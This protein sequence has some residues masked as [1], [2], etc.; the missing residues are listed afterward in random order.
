[1]YVCLHVLLHEAIVCTIFSTGPTTCNG[2]QS[3]YYIRDASVAGACARVK[4]G[5]PVAIITLDLS[6]L[7][8]KATF[9]LQGMIVGPTLLRLRSSGVLRGNDLLLRY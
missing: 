4:R 9:T 1:M 6:G 8:Y 3:I 5:P 2:F 7:S